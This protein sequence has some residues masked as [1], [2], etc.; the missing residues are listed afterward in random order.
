M[1]NVI[2]VELCVVVLAELYMFRSP[3]RNIFNQ[4]ANSRESSEKVF[5]TAEFK[6]PN[7]VPCRHFAGDTFCFDSGPF[8]AKREVFHH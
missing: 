1:I 7:L 3:S 4:R 5:M 2:G 6:L 8:G